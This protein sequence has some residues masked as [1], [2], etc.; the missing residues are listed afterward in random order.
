MAQ[1]NAAVIPNVSSVDS[2]RPVCAWVTVA[3]GSEPVITTDDL[4]RSG[5]AFQWLKMLARKPTFVRVRTRVRGLRICG[6]I[7]AFI[8]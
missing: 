8:S 6:Y 5:A 4:V 1:S 3:E 2:E 7:N